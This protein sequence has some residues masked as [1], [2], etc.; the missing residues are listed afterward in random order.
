M[1]QR[2]FKAAWT[3]TEPSNAGG[4]HQG[5][6]YVNFTEDDEVG[7]VVIRG[8]E[9]AAPGETYGRDFAVEIPQAEF[10]AMVREGLIK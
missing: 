7:T 5:P 8:R 10:Y 9:K 3:S 6:P 1:T 4:T 2:T